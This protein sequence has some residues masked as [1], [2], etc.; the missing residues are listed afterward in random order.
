MVSSFTNKLEQK[1]AESF[2]LRKKF[3]LPED[4]LGT[5]TWLLVYWFA[6][7]TWRTRWRHVKTPYTFCP[8]AASNLHGVDLSVKGRTKITNQADVWC[9]PSF[10][11]TKSA[12]IVFVVVVVVF[13]GGRKIRGGERRSLMHFVKNKRTRA[14][15]KLKPYVLTISREF[16]P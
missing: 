13:Y 11:L 10:F 1:K 8:S 4:W 15:K 7:P 12:E 3:Q 9:S 14:P 2:Y 5:P 6:T 16:L